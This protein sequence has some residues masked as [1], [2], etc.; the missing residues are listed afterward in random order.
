MTPD[1]DNET[2]LYE[3]NLEAD[4]EIEGPFDTWLRD[5]IADSC[6]STGSAPP[7]SS[8]MPQA[9]PGRGPPHRPVPAGNQAALDAYLTNTPH[10]CVQQGIEKF[11]DRFTAAVAC[12][13]TARNSFVVRFDRNCLNCGEVLSGQHCSHCGRRARCG[14]CRSAP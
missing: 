14:C 4:A 9:P 5:H 13:P 1:D 12:W 2:V 8:T 7:R 3:V 11:G 6:S 10:A